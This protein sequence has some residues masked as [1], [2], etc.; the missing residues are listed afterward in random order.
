MNAKASI[1]RRL[2]LVEQVIEELQKGQAD[3]QQSIVDLTNLYHL[4]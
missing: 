3:M 4:S 1:N 2:Q